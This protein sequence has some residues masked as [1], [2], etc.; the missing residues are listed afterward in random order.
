MENTPNHTLLSLWN[1]QHWGE[2][3]RFPG[4]QLKETETSPWCLY[5]TRKSILKDLLVSNQVICPV[6]EF[7]KMKP[8]IKRTHMGTAMFSQLEPTLFL[9]KAQNMYHTRK[10]T[11]P[12]L[13]THCLWCC[14]HLLSWRDLIRTSSEYSFLQLTTHLCTVCIFHVLGQVQT[15]S[16]Y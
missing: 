1:I 12:A 10:S 13:A 15:S 9:P 6:S 7:Y 8:S 3:A 14:M 11:C 5:N 4:G 2:M 16:N